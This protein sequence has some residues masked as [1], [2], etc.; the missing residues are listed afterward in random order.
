MIL[1]RVF[2][3]MIFY[4]LR[5]LEAKKKKKSILY[6][7]RCLVNP[8]HTL[9]DWYYQFHNQNTRNSKR[10]VSCVITSKW[11]PVPIAPK[12]L[13]VGKK[14]KNLL[15]S[16]CPCTLLTSLIQLSLRLRPSEVAELFIFVLRPLFALKVGILGIWSFQPIFHRNSYIYLCLLCNS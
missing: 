13:N 15:V 3:H 10:Y 9:W 6:W 1:P 4:V 11:H 8:C 14:K 2:L 16:P 5:K 12:N 7:S